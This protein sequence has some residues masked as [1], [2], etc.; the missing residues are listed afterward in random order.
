M[1]PILCEKQQHTITEKKKIKNP[2][3]PFIQG[4]VTTP[5][6][7]PHFLPEHLSHFPRFKTWC[8]KSSLSLFLPSRY[9]NIF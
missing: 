7:S 1:I 8:H 4:I 6:V 2:A 5:V 9:K 3:S